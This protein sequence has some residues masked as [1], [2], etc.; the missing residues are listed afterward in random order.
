MGPRSRDVCSDRGGSEGKG[1]RRRYG[2]AAVNYVLWE[3]K[4]KITGWQKCELA[5]ERAALWPYR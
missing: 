3:K 2:L 1:G 4:K 5:G